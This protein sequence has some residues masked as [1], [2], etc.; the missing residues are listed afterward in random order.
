MSK[1]TARKP[2]DDFRGPVWVG[3]PLEFRAPR[4]YDSWKGR[5]LDLRL[6]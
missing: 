1:K 4:N 2:N 5:V 6:L 3:F